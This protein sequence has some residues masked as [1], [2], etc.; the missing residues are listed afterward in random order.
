[1]TRPDAKFPARRL[2]VETHAKVQG[3]DY[4]ACYRHLLART[5]VHLEG[6]LSK[7]EKGESFRVETNF[8]VAERTVPREAA[9]S[10]YRVVG[11]LRDEGYAADT[12]RDSSYVTG[13]RLWLTIKLI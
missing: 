8:L 12:M 11:D 4:E 9:I 7:L 2:F 1:M 6:E 13:D 10:A 3:I 5:R